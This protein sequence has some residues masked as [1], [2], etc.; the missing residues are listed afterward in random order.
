MT[1]T[2]DRS[3]LDYEKKMRQV[4]RL[5]VEKKF[6][7][8]LPIAAELVRF[9]PAEPLAH[10]AYAIC[11]A[12][13][14]NDEKALELRVEAN[15]AIPDNRLIVFQ[16]AE[17]LNRLGRYRLA[18]GVFKRAL[19]LSAAGTKR[20][21]SE[22]LN[23]L[24][25][26][27]WKQ[28][29]REEAIAAWKRSVA[30]DPTYAIPQ[31][32]LRELTNE[33]GEPTPSSSAFDDPNHFQKI[34]MDRY[35]ILHGKERFADLDEANQVIGAIYATWNEQIAP[36]SKELDLMTAA[37]KTEIF[38]SVQVDYT[39]KFAPPHGPGFRPPAGRRSGKPR[40][41]SKQKAKSPARKTPHRLDGQF[42]F[43]PP[44]GGR[45]VLDA[46]L[47]AL[48]AAGMGAE[49]LIAIVKGAPIDDEE[50]QEIF[51]WAHE[52]VKQIAF[53]YFGKGTQDEVRALLEAKDIALE[54]VLEVDVSHLLKSLRKE[55]ELMFKRDEGDKR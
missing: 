30:E 15:I 29:K 14:G 23:G 50:E 13:T 22:C 6:K 12:E 21:R 32:N 38:S 41:T 31:K 20:E 46:G 55:L 39:N 48:V 40:A 37:Q 25:S 7:R 49:R 3:A 11:H 47:P 51:L 4:H 19:V 36:R 24:G 16:T 52:L 1:S 53:A 26:V 2:G 27:L 28:G 34:H 45:I 54:R 42:H 43:L 17:A 9:F 35:F 44:D 5:M 10:V 18:E 33:Y 8:A